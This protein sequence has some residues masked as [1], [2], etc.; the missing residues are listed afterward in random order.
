MLAV[1]AR[2]GSVQAYP[3]VLRDRSGHL[4]HVIASSHYFY[5]GQGNA[6]GTEGIVHDVT[7]F[8]EAVDALKEANRKLNL[9]NSI[10]RHDVA[11]QLTILQG[12]IQLALLKNTNPVISDFLQKMVSVTS[13]LGRQIEF[14]KTYQ[15]LGV[16][17]PGW[18]C[19]DEI[20][21]KIRPK[22][23]LFSSSCRGA[24]VYADPMLEKVF[25]NLFENAIMHGGRVTQITV[26]CEPAGGNLVITVEDNG[27][28]IPLD[29]KEEIFRKGIGRNTGFGL[30]LAR[31]IL[32]ITGIS[33][34]ETGKQGSGAR[35]E[36]T[37]PKNRFRFRGDSKSRH[38]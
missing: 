13:T 26:R 14:S 33:I 18:F 15:E 17:A 4:H 11:N 38:G 30:F 32:A 16:H 6:L 35:F 22:E 1:L 12:Y 20:F 36:I 10:T 29:Q 31:E 2:K 28:G 23:V 27:T 37:V 5:D 25:A 9:L 21:A 19:L 7:H 3:L 24:E 8:M 34:H